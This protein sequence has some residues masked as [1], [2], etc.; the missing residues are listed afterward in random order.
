MARC[1]WR[2]S[3]LLAV[4]A[5]VVGCAG[6]PRPRPRPGSLPFPGPFSLYRVADVEKFDEHSYGLPPLFKN[7]SRGTFYT[8]KAGFLDIAH[9]RWSIDW[10]WY[11]HHHAHA[12]L[13]EGKTEVTLTTNKPSR[14]RI[15]FHYPEKWDQLPAEERAALIDE[16]ALRVG[17]EAAWIIGI[18]HE[19]A[20]YFGYASF[21]VVSESG[22]AF[23]YE[24]MFS[25][26]IGLYVLEQA[27]RSDEPDFDRAVTVALDEMLQSLEPYDPE[28]SHEAALAVKGEWWRGG[29][30]IRRNLALGLDGEPLRPWLIPEAPGEP[31]RYGEPR[32]VP[33]LHDMADP[34]LRT[35]ATFA[36][37][38]HIWQA[39]AIRAAA[40]TED[41][42]IHPDDLP[43]IADHLRAEL[44][45]KHGPDAD[46]P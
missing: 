39:N 30:A 37:E 41:T 10:G 32:H 42:L 38:P 23:T 26:L 29:K 46:R 40:D 1:L 34:A 3:L 12:A 28:A 25:H 16:L 24:D 6:P 13:T 21:V 15:Q 17:Q 31:G 5:V 18:W 19:T 36:I 22:S 35:F 4:A 7:G 44:H 8:E 20:T 2:V 14:L 45:A 43:R 11:Y 9:I 33:G 27:V